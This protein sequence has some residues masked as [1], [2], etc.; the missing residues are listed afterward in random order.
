[1]DIKKFKLNKESVNKISAIKNEPAWMRNLRLESFDL[2]C[3]LDLPVWAPK[4]NLELDK[5]NYYSSLINRNDDWEKVPK[6]IKKSFEKISFRKNEIK[7]FSLGAQ[8]N[9]ETI[10]R[11]FSEHLLK[12]G[13]IFADMETG[14]S[15][16]PDIIKKYF[17]KI[18]SPSDNK[19]S[20]LNTAFWSGG[21]FVYVP[22]N[23]A[24]DIPL[25]SYFL[26]NSKKLGQFERTL[27]IVDEG[28]SVTY[29]EGCTAPLYSSSTLHA[30]VVEI[31]V[32]KGGKV[33]YITAQNWS[34]NVFN[35]VTKRI[36]VEEEGIV[37][38]IDANLGSRLTMKYPSVYL[39]G[40]K[41]KASILSLNFA[42]TQQNI[43][44]GGKVIHLA[45]ETSSYINS[46]SISIGGGINT[47]RGL[48]FISDTARKSQSKMNCYSVIMDDKSKAF[49]FPSVK[50]WE[51]SAKISHEAVISPLEE[52]Q[53]FYLQS[54]GISRKD[55]QNLIVNGL[56]EPVVK[57]MPIEYAVEI[58]RLINMELGDE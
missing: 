31:F 47:F 28:A 15:K 45:P 22:P 35:L 10:Y 25:E 18:I 12:K 51:N 46:K 17:S 27:I 50:V 43:D 8:L 16:Y 7:Y 52:D 9:S 5:I 44:S 3:R 11:K 23:V 40:K 42:N 48:I 38:I 4:I 53:L 26:I 55:A 36:I 37:E 21:S 6:N 14:V 13:V 39:K 29:T 24:V 30:G 34:K 54:R 19:F 49:S 1:M 33:K 20:A 57:E 58:N 41:S 32:K 2:F 56:I